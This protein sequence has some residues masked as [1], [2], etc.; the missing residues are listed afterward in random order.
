MRECEYFTDRAP[1]LERNRRICQNVRHWQ[2]ITNVMILSGGWRLMRW[3]RSRLRAARKAGE[4]RMPSLD[5]WSTVATELHAGRLTSKTNDRVDLELRRLVNRLEPGVVR[6][7][8]ED[9][10]VQI[11][12]VKL[13]EGG[14]EKL[15][16]S[17]KNPDGYARS[18]V[19]N[20]AMD[21]FRRRKADARARHRY[22]RSVLVRD[23]I[24]AVVQDSTSDTGP[25]TT[26]R[27]ESAVIRFEKATA[28]ETTLAQLRPDES[29]VLRLRYYDELPIGSIASRLGLA[30]S[31]AAQRLTR[32]RKRFRNLYRG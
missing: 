24:Q 7:G 16:T 18:L 15:L 32:A 17:V 12:M 27:P 20:A 30:P 8:E 23:G 19:R 11:A 14:A 3:E 1:L 29:L 9:D 5:L 25:Y 22:G 28:V 26:D 10:L 31:A 2:V 21:L 6:D 4:R 13:L